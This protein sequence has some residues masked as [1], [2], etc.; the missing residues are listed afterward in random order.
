MS[1]LQRL[2]SV[3]HGSWVHSA[4]REAVIG[5]PISTAASMTGIKVAGV[6]R[7]RAAIPWLALVGLSASSPNLSRPAM[8]NLAP[9]EPEGINSLSSRLSAA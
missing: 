1:A 8:L 2:P 5:S 9:Q 4:L 7:K 3:V 6:I